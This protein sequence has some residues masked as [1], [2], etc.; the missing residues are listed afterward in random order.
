M[1]KLDSCREVLIELDLYFFLLFVI[2]LRNWENFLSFDNLTLSFILFF[3]L[4]D[5]YKLKWE[6]E[7]TFSFPVEFFVEEF[8]SSWEKPLALVFDTVSTV[9]TPLY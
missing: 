4:V 9:G 2:P 7:S 3:E 6:L 1:F 5:D 8:L